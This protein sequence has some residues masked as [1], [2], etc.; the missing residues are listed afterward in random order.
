[1]IGSRAGSGT[2]V[3]AGVVMVVVFVIGLAIFVAVWI[4]TMPWYREQFRRWRQAPAAGRRRA[5]LVLAGE[6]AAAVIGAAVGAVVAH[7][8]GA[9]PIVG[10]FLGAFVALAAIAVLAWVVLIAVGVRRRDNSA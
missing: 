5:K 3:A 10:A 6:E 1:V 2:P 7:A 9:E 8:N 4:K